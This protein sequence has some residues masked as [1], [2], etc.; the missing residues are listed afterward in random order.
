MA[1]AERDITVEGHGV[2]LW[3]GGDGFP[4]LML[5]G[6]GP[7]AGTVGNWRLVLEPLAARYRITATDLIG[8][9][10]SGRKAQEPYFDLP[11]WR[12]QAQAVLALLPGDE[13][14]VIGHSSRRASRSGSPWTIRASPG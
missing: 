6:S 12:R 14:G 8:F 1:L 9:G 10:A 7:G 4:I 5:H 2:H 11:L 3:E 13:V